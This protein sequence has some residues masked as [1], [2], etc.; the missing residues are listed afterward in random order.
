MND[1]FWSRPIQLITFQ[2]LHHCENMNENIPM[3]L[4]TFFSPRQVYKVILEKV[5]KLSDLQ[6]S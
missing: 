5:K 2:D 4:L 3:P 6:F 1:I